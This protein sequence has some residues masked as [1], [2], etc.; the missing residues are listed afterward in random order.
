M[1]LIDSL[2]INNSGGKALLEYLVDEIEKSEV[3]VF[4]LFDKRCNNQFNFVPSSR[5]IFLEATL[6]KRFKFY[7]QS[8]SIFSKVLCFGNIPPPIRLDCPSYTYFHNVSLLEQPS[9][10][11][12]KE[13]LIKKLKLNL[14]KY[15]NN[16]NNHFIVQTETVKNLLQSQFKNNTI[17]VIPFYKTLSVP[18]YDDY[19]KISDEFVFVSNGNSH[20]NHFNLLEAWEIL[21]NN[22]LYPTLHLT[23]T[24]NFKNHI[25]EIER[26][27]KKG[28][29]IIN[30]GFCDP[31]KLYSRSKFL[32]YP[33]I[34]ESFGLGLIEAIEFKCEVI[35]SDLGY[36]YE[37][38]KPYL[39]FNPFNKISIVESVEKALLEKSD[40][41]H[42][43][44]MI[45][46]NIDQLIKVLIS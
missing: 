35:A 37:V 41:Y 42:T 2:Y 22:N 30:H 28:L 11:P 25:L 34:A 20:K 18:G 3:E 43:E 38:C 31:I 40:V 12:I 6:K 13:K 36:V 14:I 23:I 8:K 15:F 24:S 9:T 26:L 7:M 45:N 4:Y 17:L 32:I 19:K 5:K 10:Y 27:Q 21:A 44:K 39:V 29:K 33:S 46:N 16:R 1:I